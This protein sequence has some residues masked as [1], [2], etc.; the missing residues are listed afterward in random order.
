MGLRG[1]IQ[2]FGHKTFGQ[3]IFGHKVVGATF[4]HNIN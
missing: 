3:R 2:I 4:E 1:Y